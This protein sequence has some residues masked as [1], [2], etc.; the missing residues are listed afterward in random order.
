MKNMV[1]LE[2]IRICNPFI[3]ITKTH[4]IYVAINRFGTLYAFMCPHTP[5]W[6]RFVSDMANMA[7]P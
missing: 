7:F 6:R 4:T 1:I 2:L 3:S 5:I